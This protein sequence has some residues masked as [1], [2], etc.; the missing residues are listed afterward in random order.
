MM[1]QEVII[2]SAIAKNGCIGIKNKIPW[3]IKRDFEH[4]KKLTQGHVV[5]MGRKTWE[6]LP[7]QPLPGRQNIVLTR[8]T[9]FKL[10][11][12]DVFQSFG[13]ALNSC[14]DQKKVF[15]IGGANIYE[16]GLKYANV[17]ELTK[18]E[19]E[20]VGDTYFPKINYD[21]WKLVSKEDLVDETHGKYSFLRYEKK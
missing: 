7:I 4:F 8:D 19:K 9:N 11:K 2:I 17:L 13:E 5:I 14:A 21:E 16:Q 1:G 10:D 6:S 18:I 3:H 20:F 12:A 15:I